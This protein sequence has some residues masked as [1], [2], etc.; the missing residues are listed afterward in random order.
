MKASTDSKIQ[1]YLRLK[2]RALKQ[3]TDILGESEE[4]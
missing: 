4:V 3:V 1:D 2:L